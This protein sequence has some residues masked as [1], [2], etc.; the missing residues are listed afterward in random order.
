MKEG[1]E[2]ISLLALIKR[3]QAVLMASTELNHV[4][5]V[6]LLARLDEAERSLPIPKVVKAEIVEA[7]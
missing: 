1:K 3:L 2:E 4:V 7:E 5:S 6:K